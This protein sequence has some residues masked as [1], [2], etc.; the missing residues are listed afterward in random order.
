MP[1]TADAPIAIIDDD[2]QLCRSLSRLL[3]QAGFRPYAFLSAPDFLSSSERGH[4]KCLLI[5]IQLGNVS[6]IAL[7]RQLLAEG[8]VTP[9]IYI[10]AHAEA[11]VRAEA[12]S[13]G[14]VGFFL[15]TDAAAG[16]IDVLRRV[17]ATTPVV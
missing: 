7:H 17:T 2:E 14:C 3:R 6:G 5:D 13:V 15:K 1:A 9:V 10:T 16:I 12:M 11:S 4:L 8:D